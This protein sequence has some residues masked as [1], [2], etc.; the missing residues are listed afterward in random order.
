MTYSLEERKQKLI[1]ENRYMTIA[2]TSGR[3][4]WVTPVFFA[5]DGKGDFYW[6]SEHQ[7]IL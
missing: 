5:Y 1:K 7:K 4:P 2:T 3:N 6:G